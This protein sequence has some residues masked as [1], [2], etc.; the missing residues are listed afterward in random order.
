V[1]QRVSA[2]KLPT[3]YITEQEQV[4]VDGRPTTAIRDMTDG[5]TIAIRHQPMPDGGWVATHEDITE[6]RRIEAR[7][8]HMAHHDV[9]TE[10]PNRVLLRERLERALEGTHKGRSLAVMCLDLDRFKDIN[11]SLGHPVGDALLKAVAQRLTSCIGEAD[12]VARLGGDEFAIVQVG[13]EQPVAAT[14]LA[15]RVIEAL[16][17]PFEL[18]A[19]QVVVGASVGVDVSPDEGTSSDQLLKNADLALYR[20]KSEGR[21]VHRFF[22]PAMDADMQA[23]CK[24]QADLRKALVNGEFE[25]YYQPLV[26]LEHNE[27]SCCEAR[28]ASSS[29]SPRRQG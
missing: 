12:T 8:A 22:E 5:R 26:N 25:L 21:G 13:A 16:G 14:A 11:D 20:A 6:F 3:H 18:D 17:E 4:I 1:R 15:T 29:R 10:L 23:R 27:I 28:R 9:L 24:L 7:I 19:H 2:G